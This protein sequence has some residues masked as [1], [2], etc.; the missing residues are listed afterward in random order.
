MVAAVLEQ[1]AGGRDIRLVVAGHPARL[2]QV[3]WL[4]GADLRPATGWQRADALLA[5]AYVPDDAP[6]VLVTGDGDF[7]LLAQRHPGPVLVVGTAGSTSS[8]LRHGAGAAVVD[9]VHDGLERLRSW[10]SGGA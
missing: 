7:A 8:R 5:Q 10:L 6:L 2:D 4:P 3:S 9:P 1:E